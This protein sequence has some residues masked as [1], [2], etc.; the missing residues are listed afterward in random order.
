[1]IEFKNMPARLNRA[2]QVRTA[3]RL[4]ASLARDPTSGLPVV[5]ALSDD[6]ERELR[7]VGGGRL[8][9]V[10]FCIERVVDRARSSSEVHEGQCLATREAAHLIG[11]Q[12]RRTDLLGWFAA[13]ALVILAPGL[14]RV[15]A[16]ALAERLGHLFADRRLAVGDPHAHLRVNIGVA[17]RS[18]ASPA[19]WT[20]L[21]L[22][23]EA[24]RNASNLSS[25]AIVA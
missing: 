11:G 25:I 22:V 3:D 8:A 24:E 13:D 6:D 1:M 4:R 7:E 9:A 18:A 14:D 21:T 5:D 19:G 10:V 2:L 15:S 16:Q 20:A 23:Q 17:F 12:V